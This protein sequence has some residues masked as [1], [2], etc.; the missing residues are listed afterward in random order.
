[1]DVSCFSCQSLE[2]A[3]SEF[4]TKKEAVGNRNFSFS[5]Y[6]YGENTSFAASPGKLW[7]SC[8]LFRSMAISL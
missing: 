3:M 1:M 4:I 5:S 7:I 8:P 2:R 6:I